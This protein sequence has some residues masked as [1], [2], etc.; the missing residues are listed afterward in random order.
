MRTNWKRALAWCALLTVVALVA[1]AGCETLHTAQDAIVGSPI[2]TAPPVGQPDAVGG[3]LEGLRAFVPL[4]LP[5]IPFLG[6]LISLVQ[7]FRQRNRLAVD[8][9]AQAVM[10]QVIQALRADPE[11]A[12]KV[13]AMVAGL[14][15]KAGLT[16]AEY[17]TLIIAIK[18]E[19]GI[20]PAA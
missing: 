4:L 10:V 19:L 11:A 5:G 3:V 15:S 12:A 13:K 8:G 16:L 6:F 18:D 17:D 7:I 2:L 14:A 20:P 9:K 1:V